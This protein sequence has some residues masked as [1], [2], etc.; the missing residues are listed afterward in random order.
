MTPQDALFDP[1]AGSGVN[2]DL[3]RSTREE[4]V[5][6]GRLA[7]LP[8]DCDDTPDGFADLDHAV[9]VLVTDVSLHGCAF[10]TPAEISRAGYYVIDLR[11]GPMRLRSR[12]RIARLA[13]AEDGVNTCGAEFV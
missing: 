2:V 5:I 3:R 4:V 8:D 12:L 7:R 1:L 6:L 9:Q 13:T 11:V 10:R